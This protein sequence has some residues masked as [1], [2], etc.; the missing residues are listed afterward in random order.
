MLKP[1]ISIFILI[2]LHPFRQCYNFAKNKNPHLKQTLSMSAEH[3]QLIETFYQAFNKLDYKTMNACYADEATFSDSAFKNLTSKQT[4]AMWHMLCT[5]A[6]DF[7]LTF[8][9]VQADDATGSCHWEPIYS[10]SSTG[11]KVHNKIDAKFW[12]K[13]GK[14][15]KHEDFFPFYRWSQMA[16]GPMGYL[17]GWTPMLQNKVRKTAMSSL[18]SFIKKHPEYQ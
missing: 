12:F 16:L 9:D 10:F 6:K 3:K 17:L 14:I 15:V 2:L 4:Q 7:T 1:K 5:R 18:H 8:T 13:D 11:R